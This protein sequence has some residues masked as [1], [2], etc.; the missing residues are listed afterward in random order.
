MRYL[1]KFNEIY[2]GLSKIKLN[3]HVC[4]LKFSYKMNNKKDVILLLLLSL[5][6]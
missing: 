4:R 6:L 3:S 1:T 2:K 5:I